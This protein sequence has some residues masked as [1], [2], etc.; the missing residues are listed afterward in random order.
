MTEPKHRSFVVVDVENSRGRHNR[1]LEAMRAALYRIVDETISYPETVVAKEDRGDGFL[2]ILD[3]P[4]L[5]VLDHFAGGFLAGVRQYNFAVDPPDWLRVRIAVHEGYVNQDEHGW[6]SDALNAT[7]GLNDSPMV[8]KTLELAARA[9]GVIVVSDVVYQGV[10]R[11]NYRPTV[12]STEYRSTMI[13]TKDGDVRIWVRVPGYSQPPF[14]DSSSEGAGA[15][16]KKAAA[17]VDGLDAVTANTVVMGDLQSD[18][19]VGRDYY[20]GSV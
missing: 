10:V 6:S 13:G 5:D 3:L 12:T 20:G 15:P 8:K 9:T 7:F 2:V 4:V 1:E 17:R 19:F 16:G 11:H 14:P 18:T